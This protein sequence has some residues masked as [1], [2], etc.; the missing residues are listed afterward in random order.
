MRN[1]FHESVFLELIGRL[2]PRIEL[3][4]YWAKTLE[5][6]IGLYAVEEF[7]G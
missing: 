7:C 2:P 5:T 4:H 1:I 3:N 6:L